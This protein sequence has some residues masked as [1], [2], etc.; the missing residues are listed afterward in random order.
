LINI[1]DAMEHPRLFGPWFEGKS[2]ARWKAILRAAYGLKMSR[3]DK[4]L[5]AEVAER[6]PP[7]KRVREFWI[8]ASRRSGKDS[9]AS[10]IAAHGA[11]FFENKGRLRRGERALVLPLACDREQ[12]KIILNYT[13]A[14]FTD[15][16]P[17]A[18]MITRETKDGFELSNDVDLVIGTNSFRSVRGRPILFGV[19]DEVAFYDDELSASPD[20]ETYRAITPGMATL[21]PDSMLVGIS[22]PYRKA[23]LL[24]DKFR[25][26]YGVDDDEVL[27]IKGPTTAFN[28]TIDP[29]IIEQAF[30]DDPVSAAAEWGGEF[31]E[32]V[33]D[34]IAPA[35]ID[36]VTPGADYEPA[37]PA[38]VKTRYPVAATDVSGGSGKDSFA[39]AVAFFDPDLDKAVL[40]GVLETAGPYSPEAAIR[41]HA[42]FLLDFGV[43]TVVGDRYAGLWP[44]E[45]WRQHGI[46][47]QPASRDRSAIYTTFLP[48]LNSQRCLLLRS[49]HAMHDRMR[50]QFLTL[51]RRAMPS[52]REQIDHP[53]RANAHDDVCLVCAHSIVLAAANGGRPNFCYTSVPRHR[54]G[55]VEAADLT[56]A[57]WDSIAARIVCGPQP[58]KQP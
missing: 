51:E 46:D 26:H 23:G 55:I 32:G 33:S 5:F 6:N 19:L 7:R 54:Y 10:L 36:A 49:D 1:V 20:V 35:S 52:G 17:L 57:D 56:S 53:A 25:K 34:F 29:R 30:A 15:I 31:R 58:E 27:F 2:W 50:S 28:P 24:Y 48:I 22:S 3:A 37:A 4:M 47:Y 12:A 41:Q 18:E 8:A 21:V 39:T 44:V 11:A 38:I 40:A 13:R 9:V 42:A 45:R 43:S 14:F 16:P